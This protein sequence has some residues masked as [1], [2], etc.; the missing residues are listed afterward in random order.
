MTHLIVPQRTLIQ[1]IFLQLLLTMENLDDNPKDDQSDIL[2][3]DV[4]YI[5]E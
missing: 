2:I 4:G 3:T 1:V 5:T